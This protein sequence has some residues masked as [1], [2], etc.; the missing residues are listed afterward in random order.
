MILALAALG[1]VGIV[2]AITTFQAYA[3]NNGNSAC[4]E[5]GLA[6]GCSPGQH[7]NTHGN[8]DNNVVGNPHYPQAGG[9]KTGDPHGN[10]FCNLDNG[11]PHT[12]SSIC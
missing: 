7:L 5:R 12:G 4:D 1:A 6:P 9:D 3:A 10:T 11:N 8:T 2:T